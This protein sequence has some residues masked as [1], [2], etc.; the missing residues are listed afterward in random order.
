MF[1]VHLF[2]AFIYQPFLNILVFFYWAISQLSSTADMGIA[3]ILLTIVIRVLLLPLS[4]AEDKS[5]HER[6]QMH[7]DLEDVHSHFAADPI[8]QRHASKQVFHRNRGIVIAEIVSLFVQVMI[9]LMLWK[10]FDTGLEGAD[11][12]LLYPFT[13][14][15]AVPYN[16]IFLGKFD[17]SHSNIWLNLTQSLMIFIVETANI[18]TSPYPPRPGEVVRL[19]FFLPVLSFFIFLAL[20][21]GKKLFI[22]TTLV[23]SLILVLFKFARRKWEEHKAK[24]EAEEA[25]AAAAAMGAAPQPPEAIVVQTK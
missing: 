13:P 17:L 8:K 24:V 15:P 9:S 12:H 5:E 10:M 1:L 25:A 7:Q 11:L 2:I 23:I 18:V 3:V 21:A 6:R 14:H 4:L 20:P 22:I 16:L 19:Q